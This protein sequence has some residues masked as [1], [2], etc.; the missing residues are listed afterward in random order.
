[1]LSI[2]KVEYERLKTV[3]SENKNLRDI[4]RGTQNKLFKAEVDLIV[5]ETAVKL[6]KE[7]ANDLTE[8]IGRLE[9]ELMQAQTAYR[10]WRSYVEKALDPPYDFSRPYT[11]KYDFTNQIIG[12]DWG[13]EPPVIEN[14]PT[15]LKPFDSIEYF[16][17]R[18]QLDEY[19]NFSS[20]APNEVASN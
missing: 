6:Q 11:Y 1:M 15:C 16:A 20:G 4:L 19:T 5:K 9:K 3:D 7:F 12:V 17:S 8:K 14:I 10:V 2:K 18:K 13:F